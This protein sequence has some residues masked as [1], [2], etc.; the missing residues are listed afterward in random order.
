MS[1]FD[2]AMLDPMIMLMMRADRVSLKTMKNL[3]ADAALAG[4]TQLASR[5]THHAAHSITAAKA[6]SSVSATG[7]CRSTSPHPSPDGGAGLS[8]SGRTTLPTKLNIT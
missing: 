5:E 7:E 2:T 1:A 3:L 8:L 4:R 6:S